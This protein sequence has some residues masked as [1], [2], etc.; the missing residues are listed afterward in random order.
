MLLKGGGNKRKM[1]ARHTRS[2]PEFGGAAEVD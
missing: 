2:R 1:T